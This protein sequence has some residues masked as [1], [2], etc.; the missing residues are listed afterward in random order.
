MIPKEIFSVLSKDSLRCSLKEIRNV[1][2]D[3][4]V[5]EQ[6]LDELNLSKHKQVP[7]VKCE[8]FTYDPDVLTN[9]CVR[10]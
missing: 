9:T 8:L 7:H 5:H 2:N 6:L 4:A 10:Q 3:P 1:T